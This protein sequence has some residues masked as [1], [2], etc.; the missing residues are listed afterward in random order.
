MEQ[1]LEET[2]SDVCRPLK[3]GV[4]I[5]SKKDVDGLLNDP[6][7][8]AGKTGD[9]QSAER[10][11]A[12]RWTPE[13]TAEL[14]AI[15]DADRP[16][17]FLSMPGTSHKNQIP[18]AFARHLQKVFE[19]IVYPENLGSLWINSDTHVVPLHNTMMKIVKRGDRIFFPR[20]YEE[21]KKAP[22]LKALRRVSQFYEVVL[23]EDA[24]TTAASAYTY[25]R[26]L[27][28]NGIYV[29]TIVGMKG[30]ANLSVNQKEIQKAE[31]FAKDC[32]MTADMSFFGRELPQKVFASLYLNQISEIRKGLNEAQKEKNAEKL[33]H[34]QKERDDLDKKL[35]LL[36]RVIEKNDK[37]ALMSLSKMMV[38]SVQ[39]HNDNP[40]MKK[41]ENPLMKPST[42]V[43]VLMR[44]S[45]I[46]R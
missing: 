36:R 38:D 33:K 21:N 6:L 22:F 23:V 32:G 8:E 46:G 12:E 7:F 31:S 29:S 13:K 17:L 35:M 30:E 42:L 45:R 3:A 40:F 27:E 11:I 9:V 39:P 2:V 20:F 44:Q 1:L 14:K 34:F 10:L 18:G 25:K 37:E 43:N 41:H 19:D 26:F 4:T 15:L 5:Y 16:P 24:L 28:R